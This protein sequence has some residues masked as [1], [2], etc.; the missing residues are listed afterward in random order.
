MIPVIRKNS[1]VEELITRYNA[2]ISDPQRN[3]LDKFMYSYNSLDH[4]FSTTCFEIEFVN[5]GFTLHYVLQDQPPYHYIIG[6]K[7]I[8]DAKYKRRVYEKAF[9][10][11]WSNKFKEE[12]NRIVTGAFDKRKTTNGI[13][14]NTDT[15]YTTLSFKTINNLYPEF[16][17]VYRNLKL[18]SIVLDYQ[19]HVNCGSFYEKIKF[20]KNKGK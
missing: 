12:R 20:Y 8:E 11:C 3:T 17:G 16:D 10:I 4:Y 7:H 14:E 5:S 2:T 18:D 13:D 1:D 6:V 15:I 19:Y 9:L